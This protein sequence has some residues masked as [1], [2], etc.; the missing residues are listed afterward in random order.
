[1]PNGILNWAFRDVETFLKENNFYLN[2]TTGSHYFY[3]GH[4]GGIMRQVCVPMHGNLALK[5]RTMKGIILQSGISKEEWL[6][7]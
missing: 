4:V 5:P 3:V 1:M 2:H 7:K 6:E